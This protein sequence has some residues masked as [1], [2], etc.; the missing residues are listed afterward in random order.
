MG[1]QPLCP[2]TFDSICNR[3]KLRFGTKEQD[4]SVRSRARKLIKSILRKVQGLNLY[5]PYPYCRLRNKPPH[6]SESQVLIGF[7]IM[8]Q[9]QNMQATCSQRVHLNTG[10]QPRDNTDAH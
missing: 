8:F 7:L 2:L 10:S 6:I 5:L 9:S 1:N 3:L 4:R